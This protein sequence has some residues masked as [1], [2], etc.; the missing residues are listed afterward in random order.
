MVG[1]DFMSKRDGGPD[2]DLAS[3]MEERRR[4]HKQFL[5]TASM[6]RRKISQLQEIDSQIRAAKKT[7]EEGGQG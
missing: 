3:Y 2:S 7:K 5:K 1:D 6:S 4:R